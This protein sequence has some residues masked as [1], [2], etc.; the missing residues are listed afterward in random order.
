M[1]LVQLTTRSDTVGGAQ[2][3]ILETSDRFRRDGN[4]VTIVAGGHGI[5]GQEAEKRGLRFIGLDTIV[6]DVSLFNDLKSIFHFR[7]IVK[8]LQPDVVIIHS[9]KAGLIGRISLIGLNTNTVFIAHGW[10]HIR[11][12]KIM[13][14][15][16]YGFVEYIFSFLSNKVVCI[17]RQDLTFANSSLRIPSKKTSLV[18]SGVRE[19][20]VKNEVG[21]GPNLNILTVTRFQEPKDFDTLLIALDTI[22]ESYKNWTINVLGDGDELDYYKMKTTE[23]GLDDKVKFLGFRNDLEHF[24]NSSDLVVLISKSEGLPLSLIEAMSYKKPILASNVGGV[25]ELIE[26]GITGFLVPPS[27]PQALSIAMLSIFA[28][29]KRELVKMGE[30]S[31]KK[32]R[33]EFGFEQMISKLYKLFE[34]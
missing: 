18:Y 11:S 34:S 2:K 29:T 24:Y 26:D 19:P 17:S 27:D 1:K 13:G 7:N 12:S 30:H 20:I 14:K 23:L 21:A 6:R 10:S 4:D 16:F 15:C 5:F 9:A 31:Y 8:S 32:Y 22:N 28:K 25:S 3:Y 33:N